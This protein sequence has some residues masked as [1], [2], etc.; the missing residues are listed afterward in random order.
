MNYFATQQKIIQHC[1]SYVMFSIKFK[2]KISLNNLYAKEAYF[3]ITD[4]KILAL[5]VPLPNR[6]TETELWRRK[7]GFITL[8]GKGGSSSLA[9][10]E[11]CI[12]PW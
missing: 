6:N 2:K 8:P 9:P 7:S 10:Q 3:A 12:P 1:K 11:L 5:Y 4:S